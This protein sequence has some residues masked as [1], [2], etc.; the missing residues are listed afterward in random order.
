M[1][2][3]ALRSKTGEMF[4]YTVGVLSRQELLQG[5]A[6]DDMMALG[7]VCKPRS[8]KAGTMLFQRGDEGREIILISDGRIRLSVLSREGRELTL[9]HAGPGTLIGELAVLHGGLRT[10]DAISVTDVRALVIAGNDLKRI[11]GSRPG[12]ASAVIAFLCERV[13]STTEQ[14]ESIALYNLDARLARLLLDLAR[15]AGKKDRPTVSVDLA[16]TQ[17]EIANLIGASRPKVNQ[18][19]SRLEEVHAIRRVAGGVLCDI[20]RLTEHAEGEL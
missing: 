1:L 5:L 2:D 6:D 7:G 20:D 18:A 15:S 10:A 9:R 8:W 3:D 14:L 17:S 13:R 16:F 19:L 12:V 11:I 4:K